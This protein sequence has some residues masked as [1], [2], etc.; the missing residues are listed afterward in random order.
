MRFAPYGIR[1]LTI[2]GLCLGATALALGTLHPAAVLFPAILFA[3]VLYFFRDPVRSVP[4]GDE[5]VVSP[6]DGHVVDI[7]DMVEE[8]YLKE[9]CVRVGIFLSI[10]DVHVNRSPIAG[11][12][13][14]TR[15]TRGQFHHANSPRATLE[16]EANDLWL[17]NPDLKLGM[18][19]RQISGQAARRIVCA[20][21][22]DDLLQKGQK[23]GMIKF[24]SRTELYIPKARLDSLKIDLGD[25]VKGGET[26]LAVLK[27]GEKGSSD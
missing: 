19:L 23:F 13:K 17:F 11:Q 15:Y 7:Q 10:F 27:T 2:S 5:L 25:R 18:V 21:K 22:V 16:N 12:V 26:I 14:E 20:C 4:P 9:P 1:E 3:W 6:A 8:R 24:G